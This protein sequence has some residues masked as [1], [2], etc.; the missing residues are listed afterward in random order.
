MGNEW[1]MKHGTHSQCHVMN[2]EAQIGR[3]ARAKINLARPW[4][5]IAHTKA[6]RGTP[7]ACY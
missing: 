1:E 4:L 3:F 2:L 6:S 5:V 7:W